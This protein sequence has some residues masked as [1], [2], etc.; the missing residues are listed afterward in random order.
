M[1]DIRQTQE[2]A[3]YLKCE[4]WEVA[5]IEN[6]N[7]FIK[8]L[9]L[10]GSVLK[11]QRPEEINF[12]TINKL[13]RKHRIFQIILEPTSTSTNSA[14]GHNLIISHGYKL[15]KSPYLPSKTLQIDLTQPISKITANFKKDARYALKR[16][17]A[18]TTKI[19]TTPSNLIKFH[20]AWRKSVKFTRF[21]PSL[22]SLINLRKSFY[23]NHPI[24][25]TSYNKSGSIIGG[26]I[27][28][29]SL[30]D[31][32][33]YW[34]GFTNNEGRTSLSQYSLVYEGILWAKKAGCKVFD[35]EGIYDPRFP[36]KSWL[37][38]THFKKSF[39]GK[40]VLYPGCYTKFRFPYSDR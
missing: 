8:K 13:C 16:G 24:I 1:V 22:E 25:L 2:Y 28:T 32:V 10:I 35:F 6:I 7:Y 39:G 17:G 23:T 36:N 30:H 5:R 20:C 26:A 29:R 4:G 40:E 19:C 27:F 18:M 11:I 37:G 21:V 9:P 33:Y 38:F 3:N 15:S 14:I 31:C 12:N 34:Q